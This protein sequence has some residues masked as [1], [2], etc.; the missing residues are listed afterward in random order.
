METRKSAARDRLSPSAR[1][2][3][4]GRRLRRRRREALARRA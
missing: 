2:A 1:E 4:M 3:R